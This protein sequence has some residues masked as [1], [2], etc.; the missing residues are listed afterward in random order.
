MNK[1][2]T[3]LQETLQAPAN[4]RYVVHYGM[5][6]EHVMSCWIIGGLELVWECV[7]KQL[8]DL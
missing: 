1:I 8:F 6:V 4:A 3:Q 7:R 2:Y 5:V